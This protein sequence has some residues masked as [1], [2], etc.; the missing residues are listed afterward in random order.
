MSQPLFSQDFKLTPYWWERSPRS[1]G[2]NPA[3]PKSADVV[4]IGSGYTGL[5]AAI[6]TANIGLDT[7][8]LDAVHAGWGCSSRNGGQVDSGIKP[9]YKQLKQKYG[10]AR[11][12]ALLQEGVNAFN[13]VKS[14][15]TEN[16]IDCDFKQVGRFV[17]AHNPAALDGFRKD[18]INS[19]H[20]LEVNAR[21]I[22]PQ[23]TA[24]EVGSTHYHGG[25]VLPRYASIDP[26]RY[27]AGLLKHAQRLG[28]TVVSHCPATGTKKNKHGVLVRTP[29]K[30]IQAKQVLVATSGYTSQATPWQRKRIIP[31]GS[32]MIAT[33][34]LPEGLL[35]QLIV[36]NRVVTD[37]RKVIV[38]FRQ[39]PEG[40]RMLFGGRVSL[41][42]TNPRLSGPALHRMMVELFPALQSA[43]ISHS[44]M[45]YVGYTFDDLPHLGQHQGVHYAMGYC[46][47]GIALSSYF[48][49]RIGQQLA[50]NP[51]G[52]C[53]F[54]GLNFQNRFYYRGNPW[55][56]APS[57]FYY[58]WRDAQHSS[59]TTAKNNKT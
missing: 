59:V 45:G 20:E 24:S 55:F 21:I 54:D 17:G 52:A 8:V 39:C 37:S 30:D 22:E 9:S 34:P 41:N 35:Q 3:L 33:E 29:R 48:G 12:L 47:S 42:E 2:N 14:Y 40:K 16:H 31:I 32:Y 44:W 18:I 38:Y 27:H 28:V 43:K 13:W 26:G 15:T 53:A 49:M 6:Q 25:M 10:H 4:I 5:S 58:R 56:L 7:V 57:L 23:D 51:E 1:Q 19:P 50:G 11:A 36:N 46:G